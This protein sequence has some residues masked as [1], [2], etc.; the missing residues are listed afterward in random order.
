MPHSEVIDTEATA[1]VLCAHSAV[2]DSIPEFDKFL[3]PPNQ[4]I[5]RHMWTDYSEQF[6]ERLQL[7]A[8]KV[9]T[10][11]RK[12]GLGRRDGIFTPRL[13]HQLDSGLPSTINTA[14]GQ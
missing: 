3:D 4:A 1:N 9:T 2:G 8:S 10:I 7:C 14:C 12:N 11:C 6:P 13:S 5:V